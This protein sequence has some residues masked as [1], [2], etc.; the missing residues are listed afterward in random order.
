[1]EY[2]PESVPQRDEELFTQLEAALIDAT[3][4][5]ITMAE[6]EV[7]DAVLQSFVPMSQSTSQ[8]PTTP[9]T[10][11]QRG[12][13]LDDSF[14]QYTQPRIEHPTSNL[15]YAPTPIMPPASSKPAYSGWRNSAAK[16]QR[17]PVPLFSPQPTPVATPAAFNRSQKKSNLHHQSTVKPVAK[18]A[19]AERILNVLREEHVPLTKFVFT[20]APR[21]FGVSPLVRTDLISR[22]SGATTLEFGFDK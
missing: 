15:A 21:V 13:G 22:V 14:M 6:F 10:I 1:M 9:S 18:S 5:G 12:R 4:A 16:A 17:P 7:L 8:Y 11:G 2:D 3:R 20:P 19:V